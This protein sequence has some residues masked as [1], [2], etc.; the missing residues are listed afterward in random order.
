MLLWVIRAIFVLVVGGLGARLATA[1]GESVK[2]PGFSPNPALVFLGMM[3]LAIAVLVADLL[4]PRK[5]IQTISAIYFGLIVGLILSNLGKVAIEPSLGLIFN[6]RFHAGMAETVVGVLTVVICYV[7]VS[8]LIQTKDD[9]RFIIPYMEF[10]REV[11]GT[12]PLV[13]DTSV[14]IDG[15]IADVAES[16][17]LDQPLI[18]PRFVL[19]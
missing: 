3:A 12:R 11:K 7:C 2:V 15:R 6:P 16:H 19:Q 18:V 13:L 14:I 9:F 10:S 8:T 5:R 4:T 17:V 1:V